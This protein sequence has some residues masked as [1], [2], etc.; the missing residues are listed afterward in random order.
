LFAYN[1]NIL[2]DNVSPIKELD[3]NFKMPPFASNAPTKTPVSTT[4]PTVKKPTGT[5][6]SRSGTSV[7][8]AP[9][10]TRIVVNSAVI[11]E[12]SIK[13]GDIIRIEKLYFEADQSDIKPEVEE[14]LENILAFLK[15]NPKVVVEV[16]GHTNNRAEEQF[17]LELSTKRAKSVADWL[18]SNG[19]SS[20]RVQYKG[21]GWKMPIASNES[22][23]GRVKNQRVE[24]K[25]LSTDG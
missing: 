3:C 23:E 18:I 6:T 7:T 11:P 22:T 10:T 9:P 4:T 5:S 16:G 17:A 2:V 12:K 15:T 8:K 19:V 1:G 25:I 21:Y 24:V 13:K 14:A 20:N